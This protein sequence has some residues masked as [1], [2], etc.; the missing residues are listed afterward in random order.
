MKRLLAA[1]TLALLV[2]LIAV[3]GATGAPGSGGNNDSASGTVN[4]LGQQETFSAT[5]SSIG[6]DA[7]GHWRET[8]T[9]LDPDRVITGEIR[10]LRVT[11]ISG[12]GAVFEARGV[13]VDVRNDPFFS[14]QGFLLR[15]SDPGKF[16]NNPDTYQ[17]F[18][19]STPQLEDSC[20]APTT[21]SPVQDGQIIVKDAR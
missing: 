16:S 18:L 13:I 3:S 17:S 20:V 10:C 6:T 9:N 14:A 12:L 21:G 8:T 15:G 11:T 7:R 5:S 1:L 2:S 4:F 19:M